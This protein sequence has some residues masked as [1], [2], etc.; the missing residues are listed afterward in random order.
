MYQA[1]IPG[2]G[3]YPALFPIPLAHPAPLRPGEH[4]FPG[5]PHPGLQIAPT[6]IHNGAPILSIPSVAAFR[7]RIEKDNAECLNLVKRNSSDVDIPR[8]GHGGGVVAGQVSSALKPQSKFGEP[9]QAGNRHAVGPAE[10][11]RFTIDDILGKSEDEAQPKEIAAA[12]DEELSAEEIEVVRDSTP[13]SAGSPGGG[14]GGGGGGMRRGLPG[15][16]DE[17][18]EPL[19]FGAANEP[20]GGIT[21]DDPTARFSWLQCTRYKPP[22]LPR[23]FLPPAIC[24]L[25]TRLLFFFF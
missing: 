6:S 18:T 25:M 22:K 9:L 8:S 12:S 7:A 2:R 15:D 16:E 11:T 3:P 24:A 4:F 14:G 23:K 17:E 5:A 19:V 1:Y 20:D 21:G 10:F 13:Q